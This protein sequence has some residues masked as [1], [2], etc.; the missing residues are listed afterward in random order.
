MEE[1]IKV[2]RPPLWVF[3]MLFLAYLTAHV[4]LLLFVY[5][6]APSTPFLAAEAVAIAGGALA[7]RIAYVAWRR[8]GPA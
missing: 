5:T 2:A 4:I 6:F 3:G 7:A 8:R 1:H